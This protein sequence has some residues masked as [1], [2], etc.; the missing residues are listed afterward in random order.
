MEGAIDTDSQQ[1]SI[2]PRLMKIVGN[3]LSS[4]G[5]TYDMEE[6]LH[7]LREQCW[8]VLA[9][10]GGPSRAGTSPLGHYVRHGAGTEKSDSTEQTYTPDSLEDFLPFSCFCG[11]I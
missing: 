8:V 4:R 5:L 9:E 3:Y 7:G 6:C 2:V 11:H 10:M 1:K